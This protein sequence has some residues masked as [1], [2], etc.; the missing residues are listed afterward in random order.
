MSSTRHIVRHRQHLI[1]HKCGTYRTQMHIGRIN[2]HLQPVVI[3]LLSGTHIRPSKGESHTYQY[4]RVGAKAGTVLAALCFFRSGC[5]SCCSCCSAGFCCSY[6]S[7]PVFPLPSDLCCGSSCAGSGDPS[8]QTCGGRIRKGIFSKYSTT[9][10]SI[11]QY[12]NL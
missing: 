12:H 9:I 8:F 10:S 1:A 5:C 7:R 3:N 4:T 11:F 2:S 6:H